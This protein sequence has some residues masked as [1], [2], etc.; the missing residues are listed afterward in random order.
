MSTTQYCLIIILISIPIASSIQCLTDCSNTLGNL[1][2]P[3]IIPS[4]CNQT[5]TAASCQIFLIIDYIQGSLFYSFTTFSFIPVDKETNSIIFRFNPNNST[6]FTSQFTY[7]C[8]DK[9]NCSSIYAKT[10][11]Y[12]IYNHQLLRTELESLLV[13]RTNDDVACFYSKQDIR[14]CKIPTIQGACSY[15]QVLLG[16]KRLTQSCTNTNDS[17][18]N[19]IQIYDSYRSAKFDYQCNRSLC[20]GY[21]T[22]SELKRILFKYNVTKTLDGRLLLNTSARLTYSFFILLIICILQKYMH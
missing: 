22:A 16:N 5:V 9:D 3:L 18:V 6:S 7:A 19:Q 20:N 1:S 17:L 4:T 8:Y 12:S 14:Q 10:F 2:S 11:N 15:S 21:L 13:S